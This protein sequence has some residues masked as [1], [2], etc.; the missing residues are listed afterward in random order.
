MDDESRARPNAAPI[1]PPSHGANFLVGAFG[2]LMLYLNRGSAHTLNVLGW[3]TVALAVGL[4]FWLGWHAAGRY[5]DPGTALPKRN[6]AAALLGLLLGIVLTRYAGS[7]SDSA[8]F[9]WPV[10]T[11]FAFG[12]VGWFAHYGYHRAIATDGPG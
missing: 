10:A 8:A 12:G 9:I 4:G 7:V 11:F 3:I 1:R 6:Q 2:F 5:L